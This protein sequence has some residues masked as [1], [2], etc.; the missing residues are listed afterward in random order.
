MNEI[1]LNNVIQILAEAPNDKPWKTAASLAKRLGSGVDPAAI[2]Q[3][4]LV[5][6]QRVQIGRV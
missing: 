2:E 4:L 6:Y 1:Q 3:A 5:Y